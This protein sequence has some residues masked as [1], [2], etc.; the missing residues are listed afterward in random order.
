[1][2]C[3]VKI[4]G[5]AAPFPHGAIEQDLDDLP[6]HPLKEAYYLYTAPPHD[7]PTWDPCAVLYAVFPDRGYYDLSPPGNI[8]VGADG[9]T[10]FQPV[11]GGGGRH[12][13]L[14]MSALQA[15]RVRE[16]IVQLS[17]VPPAAAAK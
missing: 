7:R 5:L 4:G 17:V 2:I 10:A 14:V 15:A 8:I 13:Y 3:E 12:R 16:A 1:L 9:S 6:H 11:K